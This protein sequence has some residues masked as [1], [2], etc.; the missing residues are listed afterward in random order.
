MSVYDSSQSDLPEWEHG[1]FGFGLLTSFRDLQIGM[2]AVHETVRKTWGPNNTETCSASAKKGQI[3]A[4]Q[5][6][7][8]TVPQSRIVSSRNLETLST[9]PTGSQGQKL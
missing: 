7:N 2:R 4:Q 6:E 9:T 1:E 5:L 8:M 3:H